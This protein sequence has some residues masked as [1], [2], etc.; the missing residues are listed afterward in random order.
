MD[1]ELKLILKD[2]GIDLD[3]DDPMLVAKKIREHKFAERFTDILELWI[4]TNAQVGGPEGSQEALKP[5]AECIYAADV[6]PLRTG[7]RRL[8]YAAKPVTRAQIDE[9]TEGVD[10]ESLSPRTLSWL[11]SVYWMARM[12][13][14]ANDIIRDAL[15]RH[16]SDVMLNFD[17]GYSLAHQQRWQEAIRMYSRAI[18]MR[19]DAAGIWQMMGIALE[20]VDELENAR[21]AFEE[22]CE[23]ESDYGPTWAN[24][25]NV[26][27][28]LDEAEQAKAAGQK[29]IDLMP[30]RPA[31][32]GIVGRALMQQEMYKEA[33]PILEKCDEVR[34]NE[35]RWQKPS[36]QWIA[37]CKRHLAEQA[38][39]E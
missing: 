22:A 8:I 24:L 23:L 32:Y 31:G 19:P 6:D 15:R 34:V 2:N 26:L 35:R 36:K 16:P 37:E 3:Q 11:S 1:G 7:I 14:E 33:L 21:E 25:G 27:L 17:R 9:L 30:E 10:F 20:K 38:G 28:Q 13:K 4:A 18:A 29:A 39:D 5:W 12:P